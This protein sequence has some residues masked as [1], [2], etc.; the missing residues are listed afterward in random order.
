MHGYG[1]SHS[2]IIS[3]KLPN[4]AGE[5]AAEVVEKRGL[6]KENADQQNTPRT[7]CRT[8]SVPSALDRVRQL[9][10]R[11]KK[12]RFSALLHSTVRLPTGASGGRQRK[13][14]RATPRC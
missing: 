10:V 2:P 14:E 11:N 12:E 8:L 3:T 7:Q 5:T 6:T 9:A 13:R 1:K 4:K